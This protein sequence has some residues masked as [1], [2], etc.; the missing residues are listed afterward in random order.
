[1]ES[2]VSRE[3]LSQREKNADRLRRLEADRVDVDAVRTIHR[4]VLEEEA[5]VCPG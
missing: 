5:T 4:N 1:V 3:T 2:E